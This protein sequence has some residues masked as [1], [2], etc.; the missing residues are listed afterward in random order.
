MHLTARRGV[1]ARLAVSL[2]TAALVAGC[3]LGGSTGGNGEAAKEGSDLASVSADRLKG[4]SIT[5]SRFFGDC[6]DTTR[7]VTDVSK[8]TSECEVIQILTN[9]FNANNEFGI[10][11]KRLGGA[12]WDTYYDALNATFAG[13]NPPDVAVMHGSNLPDYAGRNLLLPLDDA[14]SGLNIKLDD[15]TK[16][17]H[18]AVTYQDTTYALPFDVHANLAHLNVDIFKA[19]GLVDA[20]GNPKLPSSVEEFFAEAKQVKQRTGKQFF[21][22]EFVDGPNGV[23]LL[24]ALVN[25]QGKEIVSP[26]G[27]AQVDSPE[28]RTALDMMLRMF[29]EGYAKPKQTYD[30]GQQAFLKGDIAFLL[31]GTWVVDQYNKEAKF[32]YRTAD[33]PTLFNQPATWANSHTWAIPRQ[34]QADPVRYRAAVEFI[35]YLY[36]HVDAWALGTGHLAARTSVLDSADYKKAPQR[37][38]YAETARSIAHLAPRIRN[39][40]A[41]ED[42]LTQKLGATWVAG[43]DPDKA[44][45]EA[46]ADVERLLH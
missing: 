10:Q 23:R 6:E 22:G 31:N 12:V 41:V 24:M 18:E 45:K 17:A 21:G 2:A 15:A 37:A 32:T 13:G 29:K 4:T 35:K 25:Q 43:A 44:L 26:D 38:N 1:L 20:S 19:A 42:T 39:W 27:K 34:K 8:A 33:F 36:D 30:S 16:F 7:G 14:I 40:Q 46:Q 11:V 9:A 28:T 5:L 3:G